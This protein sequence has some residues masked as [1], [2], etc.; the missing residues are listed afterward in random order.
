ML[1]P[2]S[3]LVAVLLLTSTARAE[4]IPAKKELPLPPPLNL[5]TESLQRRT[6]KA[7]SAHLDRLKLYPVQAKGAGGTV[8]VKFRLADDRRLL[9]SSVV[10]PA[11]SDVFNKAALDLIQRAAPFPPLPYDNGW[12]TVKIVFEPRDER[13]KAPTD[14]PSPTR[15]LERPRQP[16]RPE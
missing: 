1:R 7:L 10:T 13:S 4:D 2:A 14:C 5:G 6:A 15:Q 3:S 12:Y 9:E 11:C 16:R 8:V